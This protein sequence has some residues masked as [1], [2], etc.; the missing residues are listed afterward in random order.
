MRKEMLKAIYNA[1]E[2]NQEAETEFL[3]IVDYVR[4]LTGSEERAE[5]IGDFAVGFGRAVF[6]NA[7]NTILD[8]I[9]GRDIDK[10]SV[11]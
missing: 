1:F 7:C 6:M 9:S 5:E 4:Q 3:N 10:E 8:F 11:V 2:F